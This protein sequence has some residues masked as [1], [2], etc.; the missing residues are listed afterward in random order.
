[1]YLFFFAHTHTHTHTRTH[2]SQQVIPVLVPSLVYQQEVT[3]QC[4]DEAAGSDV[5][6]VYVCSSTSSVPIITALVNMP[7]TDFL[8]P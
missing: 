5:I 3:V 7:L 6:R 4:I 8:L 1:M 2:P